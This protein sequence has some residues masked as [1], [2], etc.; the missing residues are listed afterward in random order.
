MTQTWPIYALWKAHLTPLVG[1]LSTQKGGTKVEVRDF[2]S[3]SET[4]FI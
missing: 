4:T 1:I 3:T 2:T